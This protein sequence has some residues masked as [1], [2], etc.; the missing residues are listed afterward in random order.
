MLKMDPPIALNGVKGEVWKEGK[1]ISGL[2][3]SSR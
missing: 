2:S 3:T 1:A